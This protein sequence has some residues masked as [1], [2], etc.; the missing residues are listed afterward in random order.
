MTGRAIT[1][2]ACILSGRNRSALFRDLLPNPLMGSCLIEVRHIRIE[3][4]LELLLLQ[5]QQMVQAFLPDTSQEALADGIG[6]GRVNRR[7]EQLD[8][9]GCRHPSK[10]GPNLLSLSRIR[11]FG[12]C[13]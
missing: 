6:S 9:T 12:A 5:N 7:F 10:A 11:Y 1:L 2:F 4:A 13:P 3:H 8:T